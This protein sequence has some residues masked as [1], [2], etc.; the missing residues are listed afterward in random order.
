MKPKDLE[1]F[2]Q[3]IAHPYQGTFYACIV[4]GYLEDEFDYVVGPFVSDEAA[5]HW[6]MENKGL[7]GKGHTVSIELQV[8]PEEVEIE[9]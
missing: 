7:L 6:V 3:K 4:V 9:E 5:Q 8:K 1:K 2:N